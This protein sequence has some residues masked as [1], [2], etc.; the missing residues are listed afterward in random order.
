MGTK[1]CLHCACTAGSSDSGNGILVT[2]AVLDYIAENRP[3]LRKLRLESAASITDS[4][5]LKLLRHCHD[6]EF[7]E[8][9]GNDKRTGH[10]TDRALKEFFDVDVAPNLK[11]LRV[12]DQSG[13]SYEVVMRL[14]RCR[15]NLEITAGETDSDSMAWSLILGMTG[16]WYGDGLF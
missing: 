1:P 9:C 14:R 15:P 7:L 12:T 8:V 3:K 4:G 13:I 11:T 5:V 6:L 2:D 16:G 10:L